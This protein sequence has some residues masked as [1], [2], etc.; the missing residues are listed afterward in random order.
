MTRRIDT[1]VNFGTL[2]D[3]IMRSVPLGQSAVRY[4][5][6]AAACALIIAT[7]FS[8]P[9]DAQQLR[10]LSAG[11]YS[12]EQAMRGQEL[13]LTDCASCHGME[14]EG[15]IGP[16]TVGEAFLANYSA[17]PLAALVDKIQNTMPFQSPSTLS[18]E[19]SIDLAAYILQGGEFPAGQTALTDAALAGIAFPVTEAA[20][21]TVVT[22]PAE[23][24][25]PPA[26][27]VAELMR[28]IA[29]PNANIIFNLQL[30]NPSDETKVDVGRPFDYRQ[31]GST[32]YPGWLAVDQAAIALIETSPMLLTPGRKCQ[33]GRVAPVDRADWRQAVEDLVEISKVALDASKARDFDSFVEISETMNEA[34]D[35]CHRVYRDTG[36][37]EGSIRGDRCL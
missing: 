22:G 7:T 12:A 6:G 33:N 30:R 2:K 11:V 24:L 23:T 16:P 36:G 21:E 10:P 27:S 25:P 20:A 13:Y 29:F 1:L 26:G 37:V 9:G 35:S 19:Q 3:F 5:L 32:I 31:W 14:M 18:R 17:L 8:M 34:C 28:A 15:S 4:A